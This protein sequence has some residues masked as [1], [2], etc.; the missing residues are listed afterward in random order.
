LAEEKA[1]LLAEGFGSW[2]PDDFWQF[3]GACARFGR[4]DLKSI[5]AAVG[6]SDDDILAYAQ[7]RAAAW[8]GVGGSAAPLVNSPAPLGLRERLACV[9]AA[10]G[11]SGAFATLGKCAVLVSSCEL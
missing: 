6:K 3:V 8:G 2:T 4:N 7:A 11:G 10:L 5:A 9:R 1:R